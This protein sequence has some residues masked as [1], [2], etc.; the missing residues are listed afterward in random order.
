MVTSDGHYSKLHA[1][2]LWRPDILYTVP[3]EW[4]IK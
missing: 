1:G 2:L 3:G 4:C